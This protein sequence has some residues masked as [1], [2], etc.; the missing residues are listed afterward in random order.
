MKKSREKASWDEYF[1][2]MAEKA[3]ERSID[4]DYQVGAIIVSKKNRIISTGYNGFPEGF[5][6]SDLDWDQKELLRPFIAHAEINAILF[7]RRKLKKARLY[8][9]LCPCENCALLARIAGIQKIYYRNSYK[10]DAKIFKFCK[11][12][13]VEIKKI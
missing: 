12:L 10:D 13:G 2:G 4:P 11:R 6:E 1:M 8:C 7:S 3:T 9:T 5:D